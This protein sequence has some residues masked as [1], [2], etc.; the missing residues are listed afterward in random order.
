MF[1]YEPWKI[2]LSSPNKYTFVLPCSSFLR[3]TQSVQSQTRTANGEAAPK[4]TPPLLNFWIRVKPRK[5]PAPTDCIQTRAPC[6]M[7]WA[8]QRRIWLTPTPPPPAS[9]SG[10]TAAATSWEPPNRDERC[11]GTL[12]ARCFLCPNPRRRTTTPMKSRRIMGLFTVRR[13]GRAH[14]HLSRERALGLA[15]PGSAF[16]NVITEHAKLFTPS[17]ASELIATICSK[18][19]LQLKANLFHFS[20]PKRVKHPP[21]RYCQ[22][23]Q[24]NTPQSTC[25]SIWIS[26]ITLSLDSITNAT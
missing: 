17:R 2:L 22:I 21:R 20:H 14:N 9:A 25:V 13:R 10:A 8:Y 15:S 6:A 18:N 19:C 7:A 5:P 23:A 26:C 16:P 1:V 11:G 12:H 24:A 4:Q 3:S